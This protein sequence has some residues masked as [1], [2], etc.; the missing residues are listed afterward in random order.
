MSYGSSPILRCEWSWLWKKRRKK[1]R[2]IL[3]EVLRPP[4][5]RDRRRCEIAFN[6]PLLMAIWTSCLSEH[7][8]ENM[9]V[10][11]AVF[12]FCGGGGQW[13]KHLKIQNGNGLYHHFSP[14]APISIY[15]P[16]QNRLGKSK[17]AFHKA[18]VLGRIRSNMKEE[19]KFNRLKNN[20]T[21]CSKHY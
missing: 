17:V 19:V 11:Q 7:W 15:D 5:P 4:P 1:E 9:V 20:S 16:Y 8:Y 10:M 2:K 12:F 6:S 3:W 21:F 13:L 14:H 18:F